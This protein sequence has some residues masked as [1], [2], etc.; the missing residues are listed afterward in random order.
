MENPIQK[1]INNDD[2]LYSLIIEI[3]SSNKNPNQQAE[4]AFNKICDLYDIA[5]MPENAITIE[6]K[7]ENINNSRSLFEEHALL[8]FLAP[9]N[10]DPRGLVLS[11]AYNIINKNIVNYYEIAKKEYNN[12]IPKTCQIGISGTGYHS[13]VVFFEKETKNWEDLGCLTITSLN[14]TKSI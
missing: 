4:N 2:E 1:W 11:A 14:K 8:K 6:E 5:K 10:E 12:E 3:Q 9:D 7:T 13:K